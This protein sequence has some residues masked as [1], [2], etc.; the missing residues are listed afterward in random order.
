[1]AA[2]HHLLGGLSKARLVTIDRRNVEEARQEAHKGDNEQHRPRRRVGA[3]GKVDDRLEP[4]RGSPL[5]P[6]LIGHDHH[7]PC[8]VQPFSRKST[9]RLGPAP[10]RRAN[11][12]SPSSLKSINGLGCLTSANVAIEGKGLSGS[13]PNRRRPDPENRNPAAGDHS[14]AGKEDRDAG[15]IEQAVNSPLARNWQ[16]FW[17]ESATAKR[18]F[19]DACLLR[20]VCAG[21]G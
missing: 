14:A 8:P 1:M 3:D 17:F 11:L 10:R 6:P 15:P 5:V 13:L 12:R 9:D 4:A 19:G 7:V 20:L 2:F 21:W 16:L 18:L